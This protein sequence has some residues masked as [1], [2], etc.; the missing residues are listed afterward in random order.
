MRVWVLE[1]NPAQ[2]FYTRLGGQRVG[3]KALTMAGRTLIEVAYAWP[4]LS[5]FEESA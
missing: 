2:A 5:R 1:G 3:E 4:E